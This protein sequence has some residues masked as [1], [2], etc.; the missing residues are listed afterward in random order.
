MSGTKKRAV[1]LTASLLRDP[2]SPTR[3]T[4][5]DRWRP[6]GSNLLLFLRQADGSRATKRQGAAIFAL[7]AGATGAAAFLPASR[8]SRSNSPCIVSLPAMT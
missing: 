4:F 1:P 5:K 7:Y 2:A 8:N 3:T 6:P